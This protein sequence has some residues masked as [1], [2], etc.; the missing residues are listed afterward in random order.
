MNRLKR[1]LTNS[2]TITIA[3]TMLGVLGAFFLDDWRERQH[4]KN[5]S[6]QMF[7]KVHDSRI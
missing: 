1:I 7:E 5:V 4:L 3:G 6:N 2:W